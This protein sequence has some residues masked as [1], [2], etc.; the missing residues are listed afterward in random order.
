[1][2]PD[3]WTN[4]SHQD[5][6]KAD[7]NTVGWSADIETKARAV[8][9]N[10]VTE[11]GG[12]LRVCEH[13]AEHQVGHLRPEQWDVDQRVVAD[14]RRTRIATVGE[15]NPPPHMRCCEQRCCEAWSADGK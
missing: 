8:K 11:S 3:A 9:A 13:G 5:N 6:R 2:P 14:W 4:I 15:E 12:L 7:M 1:M 10:V